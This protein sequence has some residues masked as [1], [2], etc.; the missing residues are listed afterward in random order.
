MDFLKTDSG[1]QPEDDVVRC[2]DI[3]ELVTVDEKE[4]SDG[5]E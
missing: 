5:S 1:K 2:A 3:V 4:Q